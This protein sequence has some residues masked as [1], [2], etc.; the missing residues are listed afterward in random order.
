MTSS[1]DSGMN[2]KVWF[3]REREDEG[4]S[5]ITLARPMVER[6]AKLNKIEALSF[7]VL[8]GKQDFAVWLNENWHVFE[9]FRYEADRARAMGWKHYSGRTIIE[10]LRHQSNLRASDGRWKLNNNYTPDLCRLYMDLTPSAAGF[11][12]TRGRL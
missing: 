9:Q 2:C 11:F 6:N 8:E 3:I 1:R 7:L 4:G 12:E 5:L 10:V